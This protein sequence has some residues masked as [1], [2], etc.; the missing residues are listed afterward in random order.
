MKQRIE[1]ALKNAGKD[2]SHYLTA[3][4]RQEA[5]ESKWPSHL[6]NSLKVEHEGH[7]FKPTIH[8]DHV[9]EALDYEY[10]TPNMRPTAAIRRAGN[11]TTEAEKFY[12]NRFMKHL[13]VK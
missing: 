4:L 13:G 11:R 12:V 9:S 2:T 5:A 7:S 3:H 10:G 1:S 8:D 6:V